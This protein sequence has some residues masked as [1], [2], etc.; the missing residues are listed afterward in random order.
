MAITKN[1]KDTEGETK[2]KDTRCLMTETILRTP[3]VFGRR[4]VSLVLVRIKSRKRQESISGAVKP[5]RTAMGR[6]AGFKQISWP[7]HFG[8]FL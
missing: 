7:G 4:T 8:I 5:I 6:Q 3:S 2:G 1:T